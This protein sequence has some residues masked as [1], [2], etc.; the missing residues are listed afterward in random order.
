M[1]VLD[2]VL[3]LV[4]VFSEYFTKP[5]YAHFQRSVF[6]HMALMG[7][8][9]CVTEMMRLSGVHHIQHWTSAYYF[10][11]KG[12]WSCQKVWECLLNLLAEKLKIKEL[13]VA[14]DDTL[15]KRSGKSFFG[16][17]YY[18]DPTDKNPG[19]NRRRVLGH[20][21][22]VMALLWEQSRGVWF[23]FPLAALLFVPQ[24]RCNE[25][26][27][28]KTKIELAKMLLNYLKWPL[29]RL[30]LVVDNL[31]AKETLM[32]LELKNAAVIL[33][34]RLRSNAALYE[35]PP[36]RKKKQRGRPAKRGK[37]VTA[38]QL[39][40]RSSKRQEL[41]PHMYGCEVTIQAYVGI[42][43]PSVRYGHQPILVVIFPQRSGKKM[44]I[45][46]TTDLEMNPTRLLELYG[47]RFKIED[48]FDEL[49]TVGGFADCRQRSFTALKRHSTLCMIAYSLLRLASVTTKDAHQIE[50]EP[51]WHPQG[52]PS[53]TRLRRAM[54]KTFG[55]SGTMQ[56]DRKP[57]ENEAKTSAA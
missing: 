21:W 25:K 38:K 50:A 14:I 43:I 49:K 23:S 37:K 44:N 6:S 41:R 22:V 34:S 16:L 10:T 12:K 54:R 28:F 15:V 3:P 29:E 7:V 57:T 48:T 36:R 17:G 11:A 27:E 47:S 56:F 40:Q 9:H 52:A 18:P 19:G 30:V 24:G 33:L 5:G 55:F 51:W 13:V 8:P 35:L 4:V 46:F 20:C 53:V 26:W 32:R 2:S 45:F 31:Y 1:N 42:H 39:Y